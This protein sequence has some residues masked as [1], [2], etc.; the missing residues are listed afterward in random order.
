MVAVF[1][2]AASPLSD[3]SLRVCSDELL[4][5]Q[6]TFS[7]VRAQREFLQ[8]DRKIKITSRSDDKA[9]TDSTQLTALVG[10]EMHYVML[11]SVSTISGFTEFSH[12]TLP[13]PLLL[14]ANTTDLYFF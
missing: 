7:A 13:L 9:V 8:L 2:P 1:S 14:F 10:S 11:T 12:S 5:S 4:T 6:L 3:Y